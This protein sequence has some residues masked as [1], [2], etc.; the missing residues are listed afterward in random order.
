MIAQSDN[1]EYSDNCDDKG[2]VE[3]HETPA[4][5]DEEPRHYSCPLIGAY[6][7]YF[8]Q[9][10]SLGGLGYPYCTST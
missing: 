2:T 7:I 5:D 9:D 4:D 1:N 8:R 6:M 3:V 10:I